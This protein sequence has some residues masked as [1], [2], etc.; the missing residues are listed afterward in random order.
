MERLDRVYNV[1]CLFNKHNP[2]LGRRRK[3]LVEVLSETHF[4]NSCIDVDGTS[5]FGNDLRLA[6][7]KPADGNEFRRFIKIQHQSKIIFTAQPDHCDG[8]NRTWEAMASGA[9][10]FLD[11]TYI[12]TP[13][14]MQDGTH[15][16]YYD[17]SDKQSIRAAIE[18]AKWFLANDV[19]R[20]RIAH[21]GREHVQRFHK[22]INRVNQIFMSF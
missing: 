22:P 9:L 5:P 1:T 12:P 16:I 20:E 8:D 4:P 21:A 19:D 15:C 10:V 6:I 3:N 11:K 7:A 17:A 18:K 14:Y 13:K 2:S